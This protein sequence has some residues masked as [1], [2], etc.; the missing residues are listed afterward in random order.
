MTWDLNRVYVSSCQK[1][2][3]IGA[4]VEL[5]AVLSPLLCF[6]LQEQ[7]RTFCTSWEE[8]GKEMSNAVCFFFFV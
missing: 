2:K 1:S 5:E 4:V 7:Q 8:E 3:V 6:A